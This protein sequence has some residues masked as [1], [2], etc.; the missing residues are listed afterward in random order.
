[1]GAARRSL[2]FTE[3][4]LSDQ[5]LWHSAVAEGDILDGA[6]PGA[7]WRQATKD[8]T[9]KAYGYWLYWLTTNGALD[10]SDEPMGRVTSERIGAYIKVLEGTVA[11]STIFTY[12]LDLLRFAK[13]VAPDQNWTWLTNIKNRLWARAMPT[14]DK[15]SKIRSSDDLFRLGL[16]LLASA[17]GLRCRYN[18]QASATGFRDGLIIALLA[19]RPV[20]LRNL[21]SI[22]IGRQLVRVDDTYWLRFGAEETKTRKHIE[23]PLPLVLTPHIDRYRAVHRP[24]L[25][26]G[27]ISN[28]LWISR[29]GTPLSHSVIRYHIKNRTREAFG[30]PI[31]PHLFRDCAATSVAIED[32][33][34]VRI[35]ANILGHHSLGTTQKY[36]DQSQMLEAARTYQSEISGLRIDIRNT[37]EA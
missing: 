11:S 13:A 1:M 35:A 3:W 28:R 16:D 33:D 29:S 31:S 14:R 32:P 19:A 2:P 6:G 27:S 5:K 20:R 8:N 17:D 7:H 25:L 30:E 10:D 26:G 36:Y 22:E 23:V 21:A 15:A 24:A 4:P 18:P 12:V 34:H 37:Q 9:R